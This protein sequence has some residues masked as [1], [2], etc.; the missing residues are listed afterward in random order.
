M[1]VSIRNPI[2]VIVI[3]MTL[4]ILTVQQ[5]QGVIQKV[6]VTHAESGYY[7]M[8]LDTSN[9]GGSYQLSE[10]IDPSYPSFGSIDGNDI[11][12]ILSA[13]SNIKSH[14]G[15]EET[16]QVESKV[17]VNEEEYYYIVHFPVSMGNVPL[18]LPYTTELISSSM[19][20]PDVTVEIIQEYV[21]STAPS[22]SPSAIPTGQPSAIP[23]GQPSAIPTG[24]PSAIPTGQ[25]SAI[26][27]EQPS[28]IPTGQPSA[29]PTGQPTGQPTQP[30]GQP[31]GQPSGQPTGK[32]TGQPTTEPTA[33]PS[34]YPT[35][36]EPTSVPTVSPSLYP[37]T[38]VP[39]S[40][41]TSTPTSV[42]LNLLDRGIIVNIIMVLIGG[43][44]TGIVVYVYKKY[45]ELSNDDKKKNL[46][47]TDLVTYDEEECY[48]IEMPV[49]KPISQNNYH[50]NNYQVATCETPSAPPVAT[51]V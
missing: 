47:Q 48:N 12:S 41:P 8:E 7:V 15:V 27:T 21:G 5:E 31:T 45:K 2:Y 3:L 19:I 10:N 22:S 34:L 33:S 42:T 30:T 50:I 32:P 38:S 49:A 40:L 39:T 20:Y 43:T 37:T 36:T 51:L 14:L 23:T 28:A 46:K 18:M 6:T 4:L 16:I 44:I 29:I 9:I 1:R 25:P 13:M 11:Y 26:P 35:T 24:Q 17:E